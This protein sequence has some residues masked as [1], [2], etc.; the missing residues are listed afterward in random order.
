MLFVN[1]NRQQFYKIINKNFK[2]Q[3]GESR[4]KNSDDAPYVVKIEPKGNGPLF[5]ETHF[6][7]N[8]AKEEDSMRFLFVV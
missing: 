8:C 6:Y 3:K 4:I 2:A 5:C 1:F 7:G